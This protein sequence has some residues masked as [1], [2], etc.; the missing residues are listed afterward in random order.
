MA[1]HNKWSKIKHKKAAADSKRSGLFSKHI[2]A[3]SVAAREGANP[4][5][6]AK[7]RAVIDRAKAANVPKSNIESALSKAGA[8]KDL[9]ELVL[10]AYGP[11]GVGIL[12]SVI[13]DNTNRSISE[14]KKLI[15]DAGGKFADVGSVKW[16]F[17][18]SQDYQWV[19]KFP[20]T[21]DA[22][23]KSDLER[24]VSEIEQHPDVQGVVTSAA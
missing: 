20:Q 14:L 3:I 9:A 6:N 18:Q 22:A 5:T 4:E 2:A 19:A 7:L 21:V 13:T 1:G 16:A 10:E 17:E 12:I 24:I 15:A 23:A 8:E 11:A